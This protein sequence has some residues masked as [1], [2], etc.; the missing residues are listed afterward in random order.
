MKKNYQVLSKL[1]LHLSSNII[2]EL[3]RANPKAVERLLIEIKDKIDSTCAV[4]A[5]D[6]DETLNAEFIG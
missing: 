1:K 6:S 5:K 3:S 4:E 2:E